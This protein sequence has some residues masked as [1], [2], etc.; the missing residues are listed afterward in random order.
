MTNSCSNPLNLNFLSVGQFQVVIKRLPQT[1]FDCVAANLPSVSTGI[2]YQQTPLVNIPKNGDKM[3]FDPFIMTFKVDEAM[4][5]Y[6]EIFTWMKGQSHP[7][8]FGEY[9]KLIED[10]KTKGNGLGLTSDI[11]LMPLSSNRE[12][13]QTITFRDCIPF[14]L[15]GIDFNIQIP[16]VEYAQCSAAFFYT[17]FD[18]TS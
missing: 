12:P 4:A 1:E 17:S 10:G 2:A 18:F 3:T 8:N 11:I 6:R 7:N 5:N 15:S 14:Q 9:A 16:D 13:I